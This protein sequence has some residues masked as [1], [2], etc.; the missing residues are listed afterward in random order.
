MNFGLQAQLKHQ[1]GDTQTRFRKNLVIINQQRYPKPGLKMFK[2][3]GDPQVTK[4][5]SQDV[6]CGIA[7]GATRQGLWPPA[8]TRLVP[9]NPSSLVV[10]CSVAATLWPS[11]IFSLAVMLAASPWVAQLQVATKS[12]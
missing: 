7:A 4:W 3:H 1:Y 11:T 2:S 9:P 8:T 10:Q 5:S 6:P 12:H